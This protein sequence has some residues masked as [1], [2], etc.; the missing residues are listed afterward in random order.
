MN[1]PSRLLKDQLSPCTSPDNSEAHGI[2]FGFET[3]TFDDSGILTISTLLGVMT[4]YCLIYD[5]E[6]GSI[7]LDKTW[8]KKA[9][10]VGKVNA[11]VVD[12]KRVIV[13]GLK[14]DGKG[15]FEIWKR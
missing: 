1:W 6:E 2:Y 5:Q 11:L 7:E 15:V 3:R 4:R 10:S 8:Q 12:E 13:G 14:A 9:D